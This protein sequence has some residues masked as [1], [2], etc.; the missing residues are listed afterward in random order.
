MMTDEVT[1]HL[2]GFVNRQMTL[3]WAAENRRER[4]EKPFTVWM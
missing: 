3:Y 1:C 4:T 2:T